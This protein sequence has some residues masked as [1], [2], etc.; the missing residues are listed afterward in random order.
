MHPAVDVLHVLAGPTADD[1]CAVLRDEKIDVTLLGVAEL[2][3][4]NTSP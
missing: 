4:A 2:L 3:A 1:E